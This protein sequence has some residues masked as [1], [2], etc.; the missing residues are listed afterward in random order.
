MP[1]RFFFPA[2]FLV[3][4]FALVAVPPVR[5]QRVPAPAR[6]DSLP[7]AAREVAAFYHRGGDVDVG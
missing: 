4:V 1:N 6:P 3:A 2:R 5:A 7:M